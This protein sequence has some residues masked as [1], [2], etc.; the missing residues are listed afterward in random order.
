MTTAYREGW[1]NI[2]INRDGKIISGTQVYSTKEIADH[3]A[4]H[5]VNR[6][7]CAYVQFHYEDRPWQDSR[8]GWRP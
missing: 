1:I 6:V 3:K 8:K 7:S 4:R 5:K 2:Y